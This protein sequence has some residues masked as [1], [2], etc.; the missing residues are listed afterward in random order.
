MGTDYN[1]Q[2]NNDNDN[3]NQNNL[4]VEGYK[5]PEFSL[6]EN[7]P[8]DENMTLEEILKGYLEEGN[9]SFKNKENK[10]NINIQEENSLT[11]KFYVKTDCLNIK[12]LNINSNSK[13][14]SKPP[15]INIIKNINNGEENFISGINNSNINI[16]ININID[17]P[18]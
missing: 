2:I 17:I 15:N 5:G 16:N 14:S 7:Y 10:E 9:Y 8:N 13:R 11:P 3:D 1:S 6:N 12:N 18:K 4:I